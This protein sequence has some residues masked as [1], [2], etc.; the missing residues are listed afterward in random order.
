[1]NDYNLNPRLKKLGI[2]QKSLAG[3]FRVKHPQ[4]IWDALRPDTAQTTL[5]NKI[6]V[7]LTKKENRISGG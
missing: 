6:N 7:F 1:M 2:K 5:P 3:V 4:Q